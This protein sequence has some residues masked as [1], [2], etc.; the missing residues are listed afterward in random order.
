MKIA[1]VRRH[2][3][4]LAEVTE[5]P[6]FQSTS[7][8]VRGKIFATV[9]PGDEILHL[10]VSEQ[11]RELSLALHPYFLEKLFWGK[12][13]CGLRATLAG[14]DAAVIKTLLDIA[15]QHKAPK[16]LRPGKNP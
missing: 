11:D 15:W 16:S 7:F 4:S 9:P 10:F 13:V 2:A 14:A 5:E 1:A 3:L 6:H 12:K 8:R